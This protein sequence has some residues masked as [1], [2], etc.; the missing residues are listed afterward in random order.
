M[1]APEAGR[2]EAIWIKRAHRGP[3]D[4]VDEAT[5]VA[6]RGLVDNAD[7]GRRRQV[8]LIEREVWER[9]MAQLGGRVPPSA[10]RANL[11]VS[12]CSLLGTRDRVLRIGD[13]RLRIAGETRP[14][15]RMDEALDGLRVAM[16]ADWGG[17]AFA[18]VLDD[19]VIRVGA[20]VRWD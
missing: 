13:C 7:Q 11:M 1:S 12:G 5:L 16:Q 6:G 17:G 20:E 2:L 9:L 8:T 14:C 18:E 10:R 19:G 3:M 15:E 4:A